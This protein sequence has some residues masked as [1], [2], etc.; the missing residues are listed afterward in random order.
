MTG[1]QVLVVLV[2]LAEVAWLWFK[3]RPRDPSAPGWHRLLEGRPLVFT[4][5]T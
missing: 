5:L 2:I 3:A 4:V 1:V